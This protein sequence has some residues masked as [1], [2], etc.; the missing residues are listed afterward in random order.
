MMKRTIRRLF[1]ALGLCALAALLLS[2]CGGGPGEKT[3]AVIQQTVAQFEDD[4]NECMDFSVFINGRALYFDLLEKYCGRDDVYDVFMEWEDSFNTQYES[5]RYLRTG[6]DLVGGLLSG[7]LGA[8]P[9]I[10]D[11]LGG[12]TE[13][14]MENDV[15]FDAAVWERVASVKASASHIQVSADGRSAELALDI[16]I[17]IDHTRFRH[18]NILKALDGL[19]GFSDT[20]SSDTLSYTAVMEQAS[21]GGWVFTDLR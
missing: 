1:S 17:R 20:K 7:L 4:F 5:I 8:I 12:F 21:N 18:S 2:G 11:A 10:G 14:E 15:L 16:T 19:N 13:K 6:G 9:F 3:E